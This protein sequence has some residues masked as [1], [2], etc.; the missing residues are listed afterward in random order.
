MK[1]VLSDW[2]SKAD[3]TISPPARQAFLYGGHDS[4]ISNLMRALKIWDPQLPGYSIT[5]LLELW[6]DLVTNKYGVEVNIFKT[7]KHVKV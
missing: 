3:G 2:K 1:K 6:K 7:I 4:T 5:V